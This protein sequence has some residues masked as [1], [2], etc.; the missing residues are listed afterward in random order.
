MGVPRPDPAQGGTGPYRF[1]R[2][3]T[4][5]GADCTTTTR[6]IDLYRRGCFVCE[7]KHGGA[8][9]RQASPF[10]GETDAQRRANV[11]NTPAW[12]RHMQQAKG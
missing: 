11:R 9:H 12:V 7:A 3:V 10:T 5:H 4:R 6:R 2:N 8:P 1:E